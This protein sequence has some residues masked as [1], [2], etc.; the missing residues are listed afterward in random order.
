LDCFNYTPVGGDFSG[1]PFHGPGSPRSAVN[2]H[3]RIRGISIFLK[4]L[5]WIYV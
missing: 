4:M 3:D 1:H 5:Q 2:Q